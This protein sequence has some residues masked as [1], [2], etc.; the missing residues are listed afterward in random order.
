MNNLKTEV[1]DLDVDKLK[2]VLVDLKKLS[3]VV[4][5][6]LWKRQCTTNEMWK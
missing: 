1:D 2:Y 6:K 3:A 4:S 5:K